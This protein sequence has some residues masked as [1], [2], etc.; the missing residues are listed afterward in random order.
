MK[1]KES[2]SDSSSDEYDAQKEEKKEEEQEDQ[3][4]E[5]KPQKQEK[6]E[7]RKPQKEEERKRQKQVVRKS[8]PE[9]LSKQEEA[10]SDK[11]PLK[12]EEKMK[13]ETRPPPKKSS[14]SEEAPP[15][16]PKSQSPPPPL[17]SKSEEAPP[18]LDNFES[19]PPPPKREEFESAPP[20]PSED[21][22]RTAAPTS[23]GPQSGPQGSGP[24]SSGPRSQSSVQTHSQIT[25][26]NKN[27]QPISTPKTTAN[28]PPKVNTAQQDLML[29][30]SQ[31][32]DGQFE[33]TIIK[34][35]FGTVSKNPTQ[36]KDSIWA[37]VFA[38]VLLLALNKVNHH[39]II[40]KAQHWVKK[41][42][43]LVQKF[44]NLV[45]FTFKRLKENNVRFLELKIHDIQTLPKIQMAGAQKKK[46]PKAE[47]KP[48]EKGVVSAIKNII[49]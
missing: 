10:K 23:S 37:T 16:I 4:E 47:E 18:E 26:M 3:E 30:K 49:K 28:S 12:K 35:L 21:K 36:L 9:K 27:V 24:I 6:Q 1:K 7:E 32:F 42:K 5:R 20:L 13:T 46:K 11:K 8:E 43:D 34:S 17:N 2:E 31:K 22:K 25:P 38:Y 44:E 40:L 39:M 41:S 14:K 33:I 29:I 48:K 19:P 15:P 45:D